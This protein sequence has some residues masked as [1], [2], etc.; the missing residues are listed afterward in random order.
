MDINKSLLDTSKVICKNI[1]MCDDSQRGLL[2]QNI[3]SQLRNFVEY[4]AIKIMVAE[5]NIDSNPFKYKDHTEAL[6]YIRS[7][8]NFKFLAEF[9]SL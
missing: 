4:V 5:N 6:N 9:H 2:S 1:S 8:G 7:K 3:L